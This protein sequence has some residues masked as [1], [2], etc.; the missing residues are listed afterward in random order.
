M[1]APIRCLRD[2]EDDGVSV[3]LWSRVA[4]NRAAG[5]VLELGDN[6]FAGSLGRKTAAET[7]L[8]KALHL[9]ERDLYALAMCDLNSFI[10][11]GQSRERN[12]FRRGESGVPSGAMFHGANDLAIGVEV[13]PLGLVEDKL[14]ARERVLPFAQA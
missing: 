1:S 13:L 6:P 2:V 4:V 14:L 5:I 10:A 11:S 3:E 8:H 12:T 9:V 7:C